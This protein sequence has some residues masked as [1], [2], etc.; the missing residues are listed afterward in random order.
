MNNN[1]FSEN[2]CLNKNYNNYN[3][4]YNNN[5]NQ[6]NNY[7]NDVNENSLKRNCNLDENIDFNELD[8]FSP[9]YMANNVNL[10]NY[11]QKITTPSLNNKY[12][13][14]ELY[15]NNNNI[16]NNN[17]IIIDNFIQNMNKK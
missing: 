1:L 14:I 10:N 2:K 17:R 8:Q 4:N 6:N 13:N 16:N 5:Y 3:K 9:P 12:T 15:N 7:S 11:N